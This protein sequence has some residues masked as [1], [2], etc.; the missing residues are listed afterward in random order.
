[1]VRQIRKFQDTGVEA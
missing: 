1:V